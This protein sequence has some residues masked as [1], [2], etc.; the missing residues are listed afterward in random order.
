LAVLWQSKKTPSSGGDRGVKAL[1]HVVDDA[2]QWFPY[3]S[4]RR[5]QLAVMTKTFNSERRI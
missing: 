5:E 4:R 1:T 2:H 3:S